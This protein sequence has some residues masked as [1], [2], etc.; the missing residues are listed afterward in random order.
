LLQGK[1]RKHTQRYFKTYLKN[2]ALQRI[3]I[4]ITI[5]LIAFAIIENG[6]VPAKYKLTL[7]ESSRYDITAP[8][9]I[10]NKLK[11]R[12]LGEAAA[13]AVPPVMTRLD[14][15]PIDVIGNVDEFLTTIENAR[16][17]VE[18]SLQA[19][20]ITKKNKKYLQ[21]LELEQALS[22]NKL[23]ED[24]KIFN[25]PLSEEQVKYLVAKTTDEELTLFEKVTKDMVSTIMKEEIN[26][27]NLA[28]Q[29]VE[30]QSSYQK[31]EIS[32]DLMII[33]GLLVKAVL[34]PNST[35][36]VKLTN[37]KKQEAL[38]TA[39]ENKQIIPEG[40]RIL[41]IGDVVTGDKLEVLKELNLLETG[42]FD[43][44]FAMG[45]LAVVLLLAALLILYMNFFCKKI[46][47]DRQF[48]ILLE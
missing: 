8:R 5:V 38:K 21:I 30:A 34:K 7:G 2:K 46:L 40:S 45:I 39:T 14:N 24:I 16:K 29:I 19:Q 11:T 10:E 23:E 32:Q 13:E 15:I 27:N 12:Q 25:V 42:K 41:S 37:E 26:E 33:G 6:T 31:S 36:D 35:V 18:K 47:H 20:E 22:S 48:I 43:Y 9:D 28:L 4:G 3:I 1:N 44:V 17:N